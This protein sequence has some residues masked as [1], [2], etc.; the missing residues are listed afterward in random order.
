MSNEQA[1][2]LLKSMYFYQKTGTLPELDFA[3]E[4]A[5]TPFINQFK[6]DVEKYVQ[7]VEKRKEAGSK[8]GKQ[9]LAN[10]SNSKQ[11]VANLA[12]NDN[13]NVNV[14]DSVSDNKKDKVN[15]FIFLGEFQNI[16]IESEQNTVL[17]N[18]YA[19][20]KLMAMIKKLDSWLQT[21]NKKCNSFKSLIAYFNNWVESDY[22]N[23]NPQIK[24]LH[25]H[26]I[27]VN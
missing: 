25:N 15:K 24:R 7:V 27:P 6:R 2:I 16:K 18:R 21:K 8:G 4:M 22:D 14:N 20:D 19:K 5:I 1:G 17:Q 9:K 23:S 10:A 26:G 11:T 3:I 13:V 12:V